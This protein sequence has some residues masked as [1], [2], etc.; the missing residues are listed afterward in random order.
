M[1]QNDADF[2]RRYLA[3]VEP[4]APVERLS[5][6]GDSSFDM[7]DI[8]VLRRMLIDFPTDQQTT[9]FCAAAVHP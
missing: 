8:V 7:A 6:T 4:D 5:V 2:G 9:Q 1:F 3:G